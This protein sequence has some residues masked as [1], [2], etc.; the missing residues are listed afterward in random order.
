MVS[1]E[2]RARA[3]AAPAGPTGRTPPVQGTH[4]WW[5]L[6]VIGLAQLMVVLDATIVSIALPS[7]QQALHFDNDGRQWIVTAYSLAFGSL[8]LLGGRLAD[9][10]GR[11]TTFI[12]GIIGFA[13]A[14]ALG[15]VADSFTTLVAA[16]AFQG[17]CGALLA[18]A[19]LSLLTTTFTEPRERARAFGV[20]G[21]IAGSGAAIGLMLGG[22]L[23]QY[24]DWRWT[25]YVND[26]LAV[27][28][29][30]GA[31]VFLRR[32]VPAQRP[33]LDVPGVL[34][35]SGGLFCLVFGLANAETHPWGNWMAWGFLAAGGVLL[36][37]F[38]RW[39]GRAAHP[40]LPL[41]V[42]ADRNRGAAF[43]TVLIS[44]A[45]MF[46]VFLFLTYYLQGTLGYSP[47]GNGVAFLP[48]VATLMVMAQL[49]T[50]WLVPNIGPKVIVPI[51]MLLAAGGMAALTRLGLHGSYAPHVL[52]PLLL[53]GAGL[54]LAMPAAMSQATLGVRPSDQGVAS[55]TVNT[56]QQVGGS[57]S[58][59][60]LNTLAAS[61][62]TSYAAHHLTDPL[63]QANAALHSYSTAYWW[64]AGFFA[65]GALVTVMLFRRHRAS[66]PAGADARPVEPLPAHATAS[67]GPAATAPARTDALV[68]AWS[69]STDARSTVV[70]RG[71]VL[72]RAGAP[73]PRAAIALLDT[74]G[75][76]LDRATTREDG[77]YAVRA[78]TRGSVVLIGSAPGHQ[79][80]V[81][82]LAVGS[83][84]ITLD[85]VLPADA[86]VLVGTV[87]G[88]GS[89]AVSGALVVATDQRGTVAGSTTTD[90]GGGYRMDE[91][92]P[93][94]YTVTVRAPGHRPAAE[95]ATVTG[96][97]TRCDVE[98]RPAASVHGTVRSRDGRP[99]AAARVTLLD[100]AGDVVAA[101]STGA[102]GRYRFADLSGEEYTVIA[103]GYSPVATPV[104]LNGSRDHEDVD[105]VLGDERATPR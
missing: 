101:R 34:L 88:T 18:P 86:G 7:A 15:G 58:T 90:R 87:R 91:L 82:T 80:Q 59:A 26:L 102:D 96:D 16:R 14:S 84:P 79:P 71:R 23:T 103:S 21:A 92:A 57:I 35:V 76:Q 39:Q 85:L 74:A 32:S 53:I 30:T 52:P 2:I 20:F 27:F 104:A 68:P 6:A 75:S 83:A 66:L 4:R 63:V 100:A 61:A 48:M 49:S 81:D 9:L 5:A 78:P 93:G 46:G 38:F 22:V 8:L 12:I 54:G 105:L 11:K 40:L 65:F 62:A 29:L 50:N 56:S 33:R 36:L 72:D 3:D 60:L 67:P 19:A 31:I 94:R 41:R 73:V 1:T 17:A 42:L 28:A 55:A 44:S 51:G 89:K 37:A 10:F 24:L 69:T 64:A 45:G 98:L 99:L 13:G 25:L 95:P 43:V 70:V 97:G 77:G 47:I